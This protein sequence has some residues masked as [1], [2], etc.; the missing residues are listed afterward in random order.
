MPYIVTSTKPEMADT[1]VPGQPWPR[2]VSRR[3]VATLDEARYAAAE[4]GRQAVD[5]QWVEGEH[6][7]A[8]LAA[9]ELPEHGGTIGPLPGG[10]VIEVEQVTVFELWESAGRPCGA[11]PM[12]D[13]EIIDAFNAAQE[14]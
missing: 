13:S 10:T 6:L 11:P 4:A 2:S 12:D 5:R 7:R 1:L 3:A 9:M 14:V 8:T